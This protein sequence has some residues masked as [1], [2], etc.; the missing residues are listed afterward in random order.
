MHKT[1]GASGNNGTLLGIP[2]IRGML[3]W[4]RKKKERYRIWGSV[5]TISST[6][7]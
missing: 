3:F 5:P 4:V 6:L 1:Y 7:P 2:I